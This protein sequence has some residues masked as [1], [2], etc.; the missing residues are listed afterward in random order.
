MTHPF[1][2]VGRS[3]TQEAETAEEETKLET[4]IVD[5]LNKPEAPEDSKD[6]SWKQVAYDMG[7]TA[8]SYEDF[9]TKAK[10]GSSQVVADAG[11]V[12]IDELL[13]QEGETLI[14]SVLKDNPEYSPEDI[15]EYVENAKSNNSMKWEEKN[16]INTLKKQKEEHTQDLERKSEHKVATQLENAK[17]FEKS[18]KERLSKTESILS[19][20]IDDAQRKAVFEHITG[21]KLQ[22]RLV[23]SVD[24]LVEVAFFDL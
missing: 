19:G 24:G 12:K 17:R 7:I 6:N 21:G 23:N 3:E 1:L 5:D 9:L 8:E 13:K 20:S 10:Q 16:I 11:L 4:K 22:D 15:D 18:L 2:G 14:R